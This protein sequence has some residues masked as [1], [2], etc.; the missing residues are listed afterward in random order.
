MSGAREARERRAKAS[1]R[2]AT[3]S[4]ASN[5][6]AATHTAGEVCWRQK[7]VIPTRAWRLISSG[8][9]GLGHPTVSFLSSLNVS[10][11]FSLQV[12]VPAPNRIA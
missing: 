5:A 6:M 1:S 11:F 7:L 12:V 9:R 8:K 4:G 2:M 3:S 10:V